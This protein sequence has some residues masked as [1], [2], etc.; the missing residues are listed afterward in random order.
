MN[1]R[2]YRVIIINNNKFRQDI[3]HKRRFQ[4]D[5]PIWSAVPNKVQNR[6]VLYRMLSPKF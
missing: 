5:F 3:H 6:R 4:H 2:C 1:D